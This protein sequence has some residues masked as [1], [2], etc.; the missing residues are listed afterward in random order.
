MVPIS[1]HIGSFEM[2]LVSTYNCGMANNCKLGKLDGD[3]ESKPQTSQ[4]ATICR[5]FT[6]PVQPLRVTQK[7]ADSLRC[8]PDLQLSPFAP[9]RGGDL[10]FRSSGISPKSFS[11]FKMSCFIPQ[12]Y[13]N[14]QSWIIYC[15]VYYTSRHIE[16]SRYW[17]M[18][19]KFSYQISSLLRKGAKSTSHNRHCAGLPSRDQPVVGWHVKTPS[20]RPPLCRVCNQSV[21]LEHLERPNTCSFPFR[22][23]NDDMR[24]VG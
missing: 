16:F 20:L 7:S 21:H 22:S 17:S 23:R 2:T 9:A 5:I 1:A 12:K 18:K 13:N 14:D 19:S 3:L 6:T 10:W 11:S 4:H 8:Q 15:F 24:G